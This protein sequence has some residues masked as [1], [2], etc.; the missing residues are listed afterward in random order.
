MCES[1][2]NEHLNNCTS[3]EDD[4]SLQQQLAR[5]R[6]QPVNLLFDIL[7]RDGRAPNITAA[8][9]VLA[10]TDDAERGAIF[11][12]PEI[13]WT[14]LDLAGYTTHHELHKYRL[15]EPSFGAGDFLLPAVSRLLEAFQAAG[16]QTTAAAAELIDSIRAV[17]LHRGTFEATRTKLRHQLL[18]A[19]LSASDTDTLCNAW[20]ICDDF[21]LCAIDGSFDFI[22]GNPPYVRQERIPSALLSEYRQRYRTLYDRADLYVPFFERSLDL[23][24]GHG[25][26]GFICANRWLKNKYGGPLREKIA[27]D[28][29]LTHFI[30]MEAT[31]AFQ[32]E[33]IAYPAITII[34]KQKD[35]GARRLTTRVAL[36][37]RD[38]S[39]NLSTL[40]DAMCAEKVTPGLTDELSLDG[41]GESPWLLDDVP[42]LKLLRRIE[43][44]YPTLEEA[45][46]KVGIGVATGCDRVFID[47]LNA[48]PVESERKL[49]LVMARDLVNGEIQWAG[50]GVLN[51]F[52][53]DG[54][55]AP[56][57]EFPLFAAYL[58]MHEKAVAGRHVA[59]RS[60][61][62]WYRTIDRIYPDLLNQ[63]KLLVPDIKGEATFV[64]DEG[65]YYPHHN[66]YYVTSTEW[67]LR[68]LQAV[69]RSS[70]TMMTIAT[71][72]TR[73]AGGFL[74]F[75][76][77]YLRRIR[78][79]FWSEV[80]DD[81]RAEL[82][83]ASTAR[84]QTVIDACVMRLYALDLNEASL[85]QRVAREA[86]VT[87][88]ARRGDQ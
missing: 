74:R 61:D 9:D 39:V 24:F 70:V 47:D 48:L 25:V 64:L 5:A 73:M 54:R 87:G 16:G 68:A 38:R 8:L 35:V 79:P 29:H 36:P 83:K 80:P 33:V 46:C 30:D 77:Q 57:T 66:L 7:G 11:T 26:L 51:P 82:I 17:E 1:S 67:D 20:L 41:E 31:D 43:S 32:T 40:A 12:R 34:R 56:L 18:H 71:Y 19:G 44:M 6:R 69:L 53:P 65:H 23:L 63:P 37:H 10:H 62:A 28:F 55:L 52:L 72:C 59:A 15:L 76:A 60:G 75:Q 22:V 21:L 49:P 2:E 78:L 27:A 42:R 85:A 13:V 4:T 3:S 14:I 58:R 50:K 86:Q 84:S 88:K 45:G 81:L